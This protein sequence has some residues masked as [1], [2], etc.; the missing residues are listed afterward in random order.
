MLMNFDWTLSQLNYVTLEI[1]RPLHPYK[2]H[3]ETW[4]R[5]VGTII[6]VVDDNVITEDNYEV[7]QEWVGKSQ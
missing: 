7:P 5:L 1:F 4:M 3:F 6:A 2:R